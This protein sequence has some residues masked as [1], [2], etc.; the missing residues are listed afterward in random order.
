MIIWTCVWQKI[1][2]LYWYLN[3]LIQLHVFDCEWDMPG[4][5]DR[6]LGYFRLVFIYIY[7]YL[8]YWSTP[9]RHRSSNPREVQQV[10]SQLC[11]WSLWLQWH[12]RAS[13][14]CIKTVFTCVQSWF[15]FKA[16]PPLPATISETLCQKGRGWMHFLLF[17]WGRGGAT[18][19]YPSL[20]FS[21][22]LIHPLSIV[23]EDST[24]PQRVREKNTIC[25]RFQ[26]LVVWCPL[27]FNTFRKAHRTSRIS[28]H[29]AQSS[30]LSLPPHHHICIIN[31][32]ILVLVVV[33]VVIIMI[34]I[35]IIIVI[36]LIILILILIISIIIIVVVVI[37]VMVIVIIIIVIIIITS[38]IIIVI[39]IVIVIAI[40]ILILILILIIIIIIPIAIAITIIIMIMIMIIIIVI[41]IIMIIIIIIIPIAIAITITII[42]M[43]MIIIIM[44]MIIIII[45]IAIAIIIMIMIMIMPFLTPDRMRHISITLLSSSP[46]ATLNFLPPCLHSPSGLPESLRPWTQSPQ[47]CCALVL[48]LDQFPRNAFRGTAESQLQSCHLLLGNTFTNG[49]W[50]INHRS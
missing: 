48:L 38:I 33:V 7:I 35:L 1:C 26:W 14:L 20:F 34:T 36:I 5:Q 15:T 41:I 28:N 8:L 31:I 27:V 18:W 16:I 10:N 24:L 49:S 42:I 40:I 46:S 12:F 9:S 50:M 32:L 22:C 4:Q 43:I 39:V 13:M 21:R 11:E 3:W 47:G 17:F 45:P 44:I 37:M 25:L 23:D 30:L 19:V 29:H 6:I 2:G